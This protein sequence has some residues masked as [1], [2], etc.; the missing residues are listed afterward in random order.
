MKEQLVAQIMEDCSGCTFSTDHIRNSQV[1][2]CNSNRLDAVIYWATVVS[3]ADVSLDRIQTSIA[4]WS[5]SSPEF[6]QWNTVLKVSDSVTRT[7]TN[8]TYVNCD[9][10]STPQEEIQSTQASQEEKEQEGKQQT[11]PYVYIL[12]AILI[13]VISGCLVGLI[14]IIILLIR[15]KRKSGRYV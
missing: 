1:T 5:A 3:S 7:G 6:Q 13:V 15:R 9:S 8:D 2:C 11:D 14:I 10:K 12:L 4:E